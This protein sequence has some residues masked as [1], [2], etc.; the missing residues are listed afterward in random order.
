M[1]FC[2]ALVQSLKQSGAKKTGQFISIKLADHMLTVAVFTRSAPVCKGVTSFVDH[3]GTI[4]VCISGDFRPLFRK[5]DED[6]LTLFWSHKIEQVTEGSED[7]PRED[8]VIN[9]LNLQ[10]VLKSE[11]VESLMA[12]V[13]PLMTT[14]KIAKDMGGRPSNVHGP[15]PNQFNTPAPKITPLLQTEKIVMIIPITGKYFTDFWAAVKVGLIAQKDAVKKVELYRL[16][17]EYNSRQ[18]VE[19][20]VVPEIVPEVETAISI[21]TEISTRSKNK[22]PILALPPAR[23]KAKGVQSIAKPNK[24]E[25]EGTVYSALDN[26]SNPGKKISDLISLLEIGASKEQICE[27]FGW[28]TWDPNKTVV[29]NYGHAIRM[30]NDTYSISR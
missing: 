22:K 12:S 10:Y 2:Y 5:L 17:D 11:K 20:E 3:P 14:K 29:R 21:V 4:D 9:G 30:E 18:I 1:N 27:K 8:L 23:D 13:E 6:L 25:L 15:M 28:K 19:V 7:E 26:K 24:K 16:I